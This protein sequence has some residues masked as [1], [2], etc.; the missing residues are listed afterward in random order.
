MFTSNDD[1]DDDDDLRLG[2]SCLGG[3]QII[4]KYLAYRSLPTCTR[5]T[6]TNRAEPAVTSWPEFGIGVVHIST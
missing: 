2:S 4:L 6:G 1:D 3:T 5:Q